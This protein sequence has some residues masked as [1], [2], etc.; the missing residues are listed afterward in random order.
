MQ[1]PSLNSRTR[2]CDAIIGIRWE[3][4]FASESIAPADRALEINRRFRDE[5]LN[6]E[7]YRTRREAAA[8]IEGWRCHYN[9]VRPHSSLHYLTPAEF[10]AKYMNKNDQIR[11]AAL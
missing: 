1:K 8:I 6:M 11:R 5:C 9:D 7:W 4:W 10:K 3:R 2:Y